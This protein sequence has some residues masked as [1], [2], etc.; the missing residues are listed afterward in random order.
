[1][2]RSLKIAGVILSVFAFF[3]SCDEETLGENAFGTLKG[4]VVIN[5]DN[6]PLGNVKIT[7][8]PVSTTVF[9]DNQGE[10]TISDIQIGDYSVQAE[11]DEYET[12]FEPANILEGK[13]SQVVFELDSLKARNLSP[14]SPVLLAPID[15]AEGVKPDVTFIWSSSKN[16]DDDILYTLQLRNGETNEITIFERVQD[17]TIT[18]KDLAIG[19]VYFWQVTATDDVTTPVQSE[20]SSFRVQGTSANSYL[21]VRNIDGKNV[22]FS[23]G[24]GTEGDQN[25]I[26]ISSLQSNSYRPR[27]NNDTDKVAFLRTVGAETHLFTM[28]PDG[29]NVRQLTSTIPV[30]GFRQS[31]VDFSWAANGGAIY[32]PN[33]DKLYRVNP[34]GG[35]SVMVYQTP[36]GSLIS[37][38]DVAELDQDLLLLKTNDLS[39]YNVRIFTYRLSTG[40]EETVVLENVTGGAGSIDISANGDKILYNLDTSGAENSVYRLFSSRI[41]I[42]YTSTAIVTQVETGVATGQNDYDGRFSPSEGSIIFSRS[43]NTN[44]AIPSV[45]RVNLDGQNDEGLLFSEAYMPDWH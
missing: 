43:N 25:V 35:G 12:A 18:V 4:K 34:D 27:K 1:M 42:Y 41:F 15:E 17:T 8:N 11:L 44:N 24:D 40:S 13:I 38:V 14:K 16:D 5:G 2:N 19:K 39:G 7:T 36:D 29:S 32:Y 10:F 31:A 21:F 6:M 37:E 22:I 28:D 30:A 23:G 9:T 20:I 45:L 33:F 3:T 26:R